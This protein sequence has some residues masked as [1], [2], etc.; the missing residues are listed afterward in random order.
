MPAT[1]PFHTLLLV[2]VLVVFPAMFYHRLRSHTRE[3][4]DRR[5]EGLV[6]LVTLRLIGVATL[7]TITLYL[8]DPNRLAWAAAPFPEW[9]RWIGIAAGGVGGFTGIW[10][11]RT[12][13]PNLTDTVVTRQHHTLVLGGPYRWVRH[14]FYGSIALLFAAFAF[15]AANW[16][17]LVAGVLVITL[18]VVRTDREEERLAARFGDAYRDYVQHTNR[19]VP[20][21]RSPWPRS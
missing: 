19:F 10:T 2:I 12:L 4:L 15:G 21:L 20:P 6:M 18:V 3:P 7:V 1:E 13:G 14:P 9:L 8:I 16:L 5:Q 11:V 17:I